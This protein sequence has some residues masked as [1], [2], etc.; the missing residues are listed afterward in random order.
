MASAYDGEA[1]RVLPDDPEIRVSFL[2][3]VLV[4]NYMNLALW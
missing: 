1:I 4:Q 3:G 2:H